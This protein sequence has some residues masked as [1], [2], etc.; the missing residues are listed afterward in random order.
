MRIIITETQKELLDYNRLSN[1]VKRRLELNVLDDTVISII[2]ELPVSIFSFQDFVNTTIDNLYEK[3]ETISN[4]EICWGDESY[5][6]FSTSIKR[7]L[8]S[9]YEDTI[10]KYYKTYYV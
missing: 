7:F 6:Q 9:R 1:C 10:T 3:L 8:T 2:N 5:Y 4:F